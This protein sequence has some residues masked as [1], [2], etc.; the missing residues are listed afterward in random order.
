[1]EMRPAGASPDDCAGA[2]RGQD[3]GAAQ[4]RAGR[5]QSQ[6][7]GQEGLRFLTL[8]LRLTGGIPAASTPSWGCRVSES[9]M[10]GWGTIPLTVS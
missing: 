10:V 6:L 7:T 4:R 8:S 1:M 2:R 5:K 9:Q 3:I